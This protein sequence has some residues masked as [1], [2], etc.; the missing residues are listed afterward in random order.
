MITKYVTP[1]VGELFTSTHFVVVK[2]A[3]RYM[4][5]KYGIKKAQYLIKH[6]LMSTSSIYI[7][8]QTSALKKKPA[9][10][11]PI[12]A[13]GMSTLKNIV[14]N[15][16]KGTSIKATVLNSC[17]PYL[18]TPITVTV[19]F[20]AAKVLFTLDVYLHKDHH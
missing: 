11:N 17:L 12:I 7:V 8:Y 18:Y 20:V 5:K 16:A 14:T 2:A 1:S 9:K 13:V 4:K 19:I 6:L 10:N 3:H 15:N